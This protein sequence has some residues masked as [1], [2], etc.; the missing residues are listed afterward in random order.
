MSNGAQCCALEIC[1]DPPAAREKL[2]AIVA[3]HAGVA[4]TP[5]HAAVVRQVLDMMAHEGLTFAPAS[6]RQ[7]IADVVAAERARVAKA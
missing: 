2:P 3:K 5:A 7:V 4:A 6:M 1:C